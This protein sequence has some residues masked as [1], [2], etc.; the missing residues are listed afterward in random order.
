MWMGEM[1]D[2]R[3]NLFPIDQILKDIEII[4]NNPNV[5]AVVFT[6]AC[7]FYTRERA[8][9]IT[10]TIAACKYKI[11]TILTLDIAFMDEVN[12]SMEIIFRLLWF[13]YFKVSKAID[14]RNH[15]IEKT[16][17]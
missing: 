4:Y 10:E 13:T 9:K 12:R 6:D 11:P 16:L 3:L 17:L 8:M 14:F 7:I 2:K 5:D 1:Q 15:F